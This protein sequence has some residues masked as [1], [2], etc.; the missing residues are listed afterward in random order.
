[1]ASSWER[2]AEI[3]LTEAGDTVDSG[4]ITAKKH[5][6]FVFF[7]IASGDV[8]GCIRFNSDNGSNYSHRRGRDGT[9]D[10]TGTGTNLTYTTIGGTST[11]DVVYAVGSI[12]NK[13]DKEKLVHTEGVDSNTAG[14]GNAPYRRGSRH[15]WA[16]TSDSITSIQMVN[17][18]AG[19]WDSGSYITVWGA[20][21][22]VSTAKDKSSLVTAAVD[23][24]IVEAGATGDNEGNVSYL[25]YKQISGLTS[26]DTI[27]AVTFD[28]YSYSSTSWKGG[29]YADSGSN[30]PGTLLTNG[31]NNCVGELASSSL[32]NTYTTVT[33]TLDHTATVPANGKVWVAIVPSDTGTRKIRINSGSEA[34]TD[35]VYATGSTPAGNSSNYANML[36][37]TANISGNGSNNVRFGVVTA[38]AIPL[39]SDLPTGTRYEETDTRKI[40]RLTSSSGW[41]EKGT[42]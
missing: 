25:T 29:V 24:T 14:A 6:K 11:G 9:T 40:Y 41:K 19:S 3:T 2:L 21:D 33:I 10:G 30:Q 15:K 36:Y 37:S 16:N 28:A 17:V 22:Q 1:M 31:G 20:D 38:L 26:G 7:G 8:M 5:L 12:I 32:S 35:S 39:S 23:A 42:A 13:S 4:T 18:N 34:Y 27:Y